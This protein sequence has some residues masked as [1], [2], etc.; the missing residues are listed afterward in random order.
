MQFLDMMA[1]VHDIL[2][3]DRDGLWDLHMDAVQRA[4]HIFAAFD[5]T[6]YL[7]WCSIY[8]EDMRH[9]PQ[10]APS[11]YENFLQGNFSIQDKQGHFNAVGGDQKLEQTINLSSKCCDGIIGHSRQKQ[12]IAEWDLIYHE[13]MALKN[14]HREY[15]CNA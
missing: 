7:R 8:I 2:R 15:R 4:L 12:Y 6:N 3:A 11:V 10:T 5:A 13:M 9:L 14:F 1:V